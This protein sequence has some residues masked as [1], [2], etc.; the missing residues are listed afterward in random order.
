MNDVEDLPGPLEA[1]LRKAVKAATWLQ[2][3]DMGAIELAA[4]YAQRM[5]QGAREFR[6]GEIDSMSYNKVLYLGPHVL[7]TLKALG[8]SPDDRIRIMQS[9]EPVKEADLVDDLKNRRRK[10]AAGEG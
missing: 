10:R 3:S 1:A 6:L 7:N 4:V 2:A 5:D 9:S 8:L